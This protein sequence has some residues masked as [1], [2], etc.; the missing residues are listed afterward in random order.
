[1]TTTKRLDFSDFD[2]A[3]DNN[4]LNSEF[5]VEVQTNTNIS[6]V[7]L[8]GL[9]TEYKSFEFTIQGTE[10]SRF[11]TSKIM[12]IAD[13]NPTPNIFFTEYSSVFNASPVGSFN[14]VGSLNEIQLQVQSNTSNPTDYIVR[15]NATRRTS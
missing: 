8:V 5:S 6:P 1:M 7:L 11:Q 9:A 4:F 2:D 15:V 3:L 12:G 13:D 14:I 10:G